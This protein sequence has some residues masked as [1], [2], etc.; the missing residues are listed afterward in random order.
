VNESKVIRASFLETEAHYL[1]AARRNPRRP[2]AFISACIGFFIAAAVLTPII[3]RDRARGDRQWWLQFVVLG[4]AAGLIVWAMSPA[5]QRRRLV[6]ALRKMLAHPPSTSHFEFSDAGFL[7]TGKD[8]RSSFHPWTTV[9]EAVRFPDGLTIVFDAE[10]TAYF[11]IPRDAFASEADYQNVL[12]T[13][14][15]KVLRV[16]HRSQ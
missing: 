15:R 5:T 14:A 1:V 12:D 10:T 13:V 3:L 8:G 4:I 2:R 7:S 16:D 11:W 6:K 9:P